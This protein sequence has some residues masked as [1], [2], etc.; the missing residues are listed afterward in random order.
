MLQEIKIKKQE[1]CRGVKRCQRSLCDPEQPK[2]QQESSWGDSSRGDGGQGRPWACRA[3]QRGNPTA[4]QG[5]RRT[6]IITNQ[7]KAQG[8]LEDSQ[9]RQVRDGKGTQI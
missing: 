5:M 4:P 9:Q 2:G 8:G 6:G 1:S 7:S 3:E